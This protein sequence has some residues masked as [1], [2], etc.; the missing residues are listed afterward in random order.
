MTLHSN[1]IQ[2][3]AHVLPVS[4]A[5]LVD[6]D[7]SLTFRI[8]PGSDEVSNFVYKVGAHRFDELLAAEV[9]QS[10]R[11][12]VYSVTYDQVNDLREE[13]A[14]IVFSTL[15]SKFAMYG[16]TILNVLVSNVALPIDIQN[17]LETMTAL[18][19]EMAEQEKLHKNRLRAIE[20]EAARSIETIRISN[21]RKLQEIDAQMKR[22]DIERLEMEEAARGRARLEEIKAMAVAD[23]ALNKSIGDA[24]LEKLKA[25]Q[26]AEG[27]LKK[28]HLQCQAM[29][30][31][32]EA[33]VKVELQKSEANLAVAESR[34]VSVLHRDYLFLVRFHS[35]K[36]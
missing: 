34:A 15:T 8:G 13:F 22:N 31:E 9:E 18:Q 10:I 33:K 27:V 1:R 5:V 32:T 11:T 3:N 2:T 6:V 20:D 29:Q 14:A 17:Q 19:L 21:Q 30:I 7:L 4:T 35:V 16:V 24:N 36:Y 25:R 23:V 28:Y 12:L 26:D